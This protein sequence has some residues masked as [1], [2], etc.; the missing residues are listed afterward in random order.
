MINLI[1]QFLKFGVV[2]AICFVI[3]FTL[4]TTL[5]FLGC[6]YLISGI[7]SFVVSVV[8]NYLLSMKFVFER[9]EDISRRREFIVYVI[10]S[11]IGLGLNEL[12]LYI[13]V[14]IIYKNWNFL[15]EI[16]NDRW[17]EIIAKVIATGIVMIYNFVSRK[18]FLEKKDEKVDE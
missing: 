18:I 6:P 10:L 5:N 4:Y 9:R 7:I 12:I 17:S 3:D 14:D 2:G 8:V 11:T 15:Q 1:K 13:C 16:Y